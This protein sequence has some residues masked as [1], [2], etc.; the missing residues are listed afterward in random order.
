MLLVEF[1]LKDS[2]ARSSGS[3]FNHRAW[4]VEAGDLCASDLGGSH[5]KFQDSQ[6]H[7]VKPCLNLGWWQGVGEM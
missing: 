7:A 2:A 3:T 5:S 4:E 1:K 6:S